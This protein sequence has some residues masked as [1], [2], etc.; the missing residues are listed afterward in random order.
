[1]KKLFTLILVSMALAVT[2]HAEEQN[3]R[4]FQFVDANGNEVADGSVITVSELNAEGQMVVP[5]RVKNVSG[6]KAAAS[7]YEEINEKPGGEW[8]TCAFGNCQT[9]TQ[10]GYSPKSVVDADYE[11]SIQTEWIPEAGKYA[12]WTAT[13]QV[14]VFNIT[15]KKQFGRDVDAVGD[16]IIG[17]GPKVTVRFR[18][19]DPAH[20]DATGAKGTTVSRIYSANGCRLSTMRR[21]LNIV[22]LANGHA[23]KVFKP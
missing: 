5:L 14:H 3:D 20:I 7:I 2:T 22:K 16:N 11:K 23:F 1:M 19:M 9:M 17:Y 6:Q 4:T 12:E 21:G 13:L 18:Y 15:T 8:Q 10:N